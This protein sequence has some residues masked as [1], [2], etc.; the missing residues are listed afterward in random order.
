MLYECAAHGTRV[1]SLEVEYIGW[2]LV[3]MFTHDLEGFGANW[4]SPKPLAALAVMDPVWPVVRSLM[5][6]WNPSAVSPIATERLSPECMNRSCVLSGVR[7]A[8]VASTGL[9][10]A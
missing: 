1:F 2:K 7:C 4:T 9:A 8:S 6:T 10:G 5:R 3:G